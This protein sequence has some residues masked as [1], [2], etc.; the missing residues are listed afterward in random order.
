MANGFCKSFILPWHVLTCHEDC[1]LRSVMSSCI[2]IHSCARET[3]WWKSNQMKLTSK[4]HRCCIPST[5][6]LQRQAAALLLQTPPPDTPYK[7]SART[8]SDA[9]IPPPLGAICQVPP[10][11]PLSVGTA[12]GLASF[13]WGL[14]H[15]SINACTPSP[16]A[17]L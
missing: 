17:N 8:R 7:M 12:D 14:A 1:N 16:G 3:S 6:T 4:Q 2:P 13:S 15:L 5:S 9:A 11:P 10:P